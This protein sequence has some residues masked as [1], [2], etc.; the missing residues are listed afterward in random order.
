MKMQ[1]INF[2]ILFTSLIVFV[3]L[4][5]FSA[6]AQEN[7]AD[8]Y[9][10]LFYFNTTKNPDNSRL[11][12]V[13]F[14]GRNKEDK[15]DKIAV[16]AAPI[17]FFNVFD[18]EE[19]LLGKA[20]TN[21]KGIAEITL[22]PDQ[23]YLV[24]EE[25]YINFLARFEGTDGLEDEE[26]ELMIIDLKLELELLTEDS[27]HMAYLNAYTL[28]SVGEQVPVEE[29]EIIV[30]VESLISTMALAEDY[31]EDGEYE[32][33]IGND[34]P[35]DQDGNFVVN[36]LVDE[37]DEFGTVIQKQSVNWG[38]RKD[39]LVEAKNELWTDGA[40]T[41][42]YIVLTI[43]LVGVWAFYVYTVLNLRKIKKLGNY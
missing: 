12:E 11:L 7:D 2:S 13:E 25:G 37:H 38:T 29:L 22:S 6:A 27:I 30:G 35:G 28:D 42:M 15:R 26:E 32:L 1:K 4:F 40:P 18:G 31:L 24:D 8:N 17:E 3:F 41:W 9:R 36:V 33:E 14:L 5:N 20:N 10:T 21:N 39:K 19:I 43:M 34:I 16:I 23:E